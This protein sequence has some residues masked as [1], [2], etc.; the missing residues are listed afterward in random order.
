MLAALDGIISIQMRLVELD[1]DHLA[2]PSKQEDFKNNFQFHDDISLSF[3]AAA[4]ITAC[5]TKAIFKRF[6]GRKL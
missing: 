1:D 3:L 4:I 2:S 5:T 6:F